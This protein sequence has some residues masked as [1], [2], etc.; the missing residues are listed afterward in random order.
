V[1][2]VLQLSKEE[3]SSALLEQENKGVTALVVQVLRLAN[4]GSSTRSRQ[5]PITSNTQALG[6]VGSCQL[7]R[8]CC[9]LMYLDSHDKSQQCDPIITL[10]ERRAG[11][12][13][14][15]AAVLRG[16]DREFTQC[17]WLTG[18]LF[19]VHI[20]NGAVAGDLVRDLPIDSSIKDAIAERTGDLG[21]LASIGES[22]ETGDFDRA[23][24]QSCNLE[25]KFVSRLPDL[26]W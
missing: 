11:F 16:K 9:L 20:R 5:A 26:G 18:S 2:K 19:L 12:M 22:M 24:A 23:R 14:Q 15:G 8:W 7:A 3:A 6:F 13:K 10:V 4:N 25:S 21:R 17:A 1:S